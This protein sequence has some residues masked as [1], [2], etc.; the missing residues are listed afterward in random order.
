MRGPGSWRLRATSVLA[1][2][3]LMMAGCGADTASPSPQPGGA[4]GAW[5]SATS[6]PQP[7]GTIYILAPV[8][9]L[10][11]IDPQRVYSG[12]YLAFFGAT[13]Y[14]SLVSYTYSANAVEAGTLIPDM[15]TDTGRASADAKTWTFALRDGLT[16]QDGSPIT[17]AD[18]A[19]GVSRT[20]ATDVISDG[21]T[22]AIQY[23]DIPTN[24]DGSSQYPG[25][26]K[27]TAA[28]QALYGKAVTCS[29][30]NK[31]ITFHLNQARSDFNYTTTL[32]FSPV[33]NPADHPGVDTGE[34]YGDH[35][36][37]SG[38]YQIDSYAPGTGGRMILVRNPRWNPSS[39][40]IRKAYP[41]RWEI[42]FG[43]DPVLIDQ[44]LMSSQD[45]N[46]YA[47][48]PW[49][50]QPQ[51]LAS[52]FMDA[53][54]PNPQFAGRAYSALDVY[55]GYY[56]INVRKVPNVRIRQAMAA[57]LDRAAI[58][59]NAGGAFAG[60]LAD[61]LIQPTLGDQYAPTGM[62]DSLLGQKIPDSGDP[63]YAK[64]LIRESGEAA[65]NLTLDFPVTA[66]QGKEA[67]IVKDSL[68]KAGFQVS[69]NPI[70]QSAY[71][72]VL[73]DP[74]ASHELGWSAWGPDWPNASTVIPPLFT[75]TG[76]WDLS[77]V[78]QS[79]AGTNDS[80]WNDKVA[81]ALGELD[82]A[83]QAR[84]WQDLNQEAMQKVFVIP[85]TFN[86][87][88]FVAGSKVKPI[89]QWAPYSSLPFG[90]LYVVQ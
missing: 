22:Y 29:A 12:G 46:A 36:V 51:D 25:P 58:R 59:L 27:A 31:T 71:W 4:G 30:D 53:T 45:K 82:H 67:A 44:L 65:P 70:Q 69:L 33:P 61:G 87:T 1:A 14:R 88:Q 18:V 47:I 80:A 68:E 19:Y 11:E 49:S 3:T 16:F 41:D 76:G 10:D 55:V 85:T 79:N 74:A 15:A 42:D 62:W 6:A 38:P 50:I 81:A 72:S 48:S 64:Q 8:E 2:T 34:K 63:E 78:D 60:D 73:P 90:E 40:P 32:G 20:F 57:A 28:Q 77:R 89:Y 13:I 35:P 9:Q 5:P 21:P 23:L 83:T 26:Y 17:C 7:G 86:R 52:V 56:W 43:L 37:S 39:D 84:M 66:T 75:E 24:A 54:T